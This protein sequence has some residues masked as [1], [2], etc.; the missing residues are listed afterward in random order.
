MKKERKGEEK[1]EIYE[2]FTEDRRAEGIAQHFSIS[3]PIFGQG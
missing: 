2:P 1:N 3:Y